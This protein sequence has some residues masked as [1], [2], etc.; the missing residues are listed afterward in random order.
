[1]ARSTAA[2]GAFSIVAIDKFIQATRDSGYKSTVNAV[3]E[4]VDNSIQAGAR[5]IAINIVAT[6]DETWPLVV[7][8]LDDGCGM[9]AE[10]LRT[11]MRFGGSSRFNDRSGLGRYGMGLP[12][13]SLSQ[14]R[15]VEVTSWRSGSPPLRTH[16]DVDEI[17]AGTCVE[18]P[19]PEQVRRPPEALGPTGTL[20]R[21][22]RCDRLDNVRGSTVVRKLHNGLG[23]KFRYFLWEEGSITINGSGVDPVDP[24]YLREDSVTTGAEQ[25]GNDIVV[26]MEVDGCVGEVRIR[27]SLLPVLRWSGLSNDDKRRLGIA[28][29]AGVSVVRAGREVDYGWFFMGEK[30][31][32]NYDDWWRCE[33]RFDPVLDEVFG[34]THTKQQISPKHLVVQEVEPDVERL[35]HALNKKVRELHAQ[36]KQAPAT[37][38]AEEHAKKK[39]RKLAP[40]PDPTTSAA[41]EK[42]DRLKRREPTLRAE[43]K[44]DATATE[45]RLVEDSDPSTTFY[46]VLHESG[47]LVVTVDQQHRFFRRVY[48]PIV[49]GQVEGTEAVHDGIRLLL[50]AAGR[51]E[52]VLSSEHGPAIRRF[53]EEW[54]RVLATFLEG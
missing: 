7:T 5:N 14:A 45:Y 54:S 29:G 10:T 39:D 52:A 4:L 50:M 17:A 24:L 31:R 49:E 18:V 44:V 16:L 22:S 11:A 15:R 34:I 12:N 32:E 36:A 43:P 51:A 25:F 27:F 6:D 42:L 37:N 35:A 48:R 40:L 30:R 8:V 47:R 28:K 21:W 38:R 9:G 19:E 3:S 13:A 26:P 20:V 46:D 53:R 41:S 1:M 33:V 23:R 2:D